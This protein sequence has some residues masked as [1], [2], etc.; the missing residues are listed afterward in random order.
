MLDVA[1]NAEV[2][3]DQLV[4]LSVQPFYPSSYVEPGMENLRQACYWPGYS[5]DFLVSLARRTLNRTSHVPTK[6]MVNAVCRFHSDKILFL[7][8]LM[9]GDAMA[10]GCALSHLLE[11]FSGKPSLEMV[12]EMML[13]VKPRLGHLQQAYRLKCDFKVRKLLVKHGAPADRKTWEIARTSN[14]CE[15]DSTLLDIATTLDEKVH[16]GQFNSDALVFQREHEISTESLN[17]IL[18]SMKNDPVP[19]MTIFMMLLEAGAKPNTETLKLALR[20]KLSTTVIRVLLQKGAV[21]NAK[22]L[23]LAMKCR[24]AVELVPMLLRCNAPGTMEVLEAEANSCDLIGW[25]ACE[26]LYDMLANR[27]Y[28]TEEV[29][30]GLIPLVQM[31]SDAGDW[32][33][34]PLLRMGVKPTET[35]MEIAEYYE[36]DTHILCLLEDHME[37]EA[38]DKK[39][40]PS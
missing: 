24:H 40:A 14:H 25:C 16:L 39:P 35:T 26:S 34:R 7:S 32:I 8:H 13:Y 19:H 6:E 37:E 28:L 2:S 4:P 36:V 23:V 1:D 27:M 9:N 18:R 29:L 11:P 31:G 20:A 3:E 33:L 22:C 17:S 21:P 15:G 10:D 30:N 38:A 12:E 5:Q